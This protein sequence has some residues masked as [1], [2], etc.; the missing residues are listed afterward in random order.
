MPRSLLAALAAAAILV[1]G[2][3]ARD[4]PQRPREQ[5]PPAPAAPTAP[6]RDGR[7]DDAL[8]VAPN[9]SDAGL[10]TRFAPCA[11]FDR[12]F[13]VARPGRHV[14][15]LGGVYPTQTVLNDPTKVDGSP[16]VVFEPAS[17][18]PVELAGDL[19][20][21]GSHAVFR[22][23]KLRKLLN[24]IPDGLAPVPAAFSS[25]DVVF[26]DLDG[27]TFNIGPAHDVAIEGG[28]WGPSLFCYARN[29]AAHADPT[30]WCP[31]GSPYAA[32]GNTQ[33][34]AEN[35]IGPNGSLLGLWPHDIVIDGARI[36]DQNSLDLGGMHT[37]GLFVVSGYDITVR[38]TVFQRNAVYDV[39]VQD[40]TT[41]DCCGMTFGT[42]HDLL[43][44]NNWF[45]APVLGVND[46]GADRND[47]QPELQLDVRGPTTWRNVLIR[48]NSFT[49]GLDLGM[50]GSPV[51]DRVRVIGNVGHSPGLE[52]NCYPGVVW[53][54][55]A[56]VGPPCG[57]TDRALAALPYRSA[58]LG[59]EDYHLSGG[60][61]VDLVT[62]SGP[63]E[64]L[65]TDIDGD[66]R[67][68]GRARDA[69]SDERA[70]WGER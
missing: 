38:N 11:S 70:S 41:P 40:F 33:G 25:H 32:M 19:V 34:S 42:P 13:H 69:G 66:R 53:A 65:A 63:D 61:A 26:E 4:E 62:G 24:D 20:M 10:C 21:M 44:E 56:W 16:P 35:H 17:R 15:I 2:A 8:Y 28:D 9:G 18:A 27:E 47:G 14:E 6:D 54:Y 51:Y 48:F 50:D 49:N 7:G 43:F 64:Q 39:Q 37:G 36:H 22:D 60:A 46:A 5:A 23:F 45:G 55:N 30:T 12:A 29:D 58:Q 67:P 31:P 52:L 1:P 57:P 59:S 68:G 3:A